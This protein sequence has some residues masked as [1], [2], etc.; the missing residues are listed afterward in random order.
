MA[1]TYTTYLTALATI[2]GIP[3]T[4]EAF[5]AIVPSAIDYAEGRI[6]RELDM[7]AANVR[8]SSGTLTGGDRNFTLPIAVG[9]FQVVDGINVITPAAA[10]SA[11][12]GTRNACAPVS[13][14]VLDM[15]YPSSTGSGVPSMFAYLSQSDVSG[16]KHVLFGPWPDANYRVEVVGK[17][18]PPPLSVSVTTTFLSTYLPDL[19]LAA[20]MVFMTGFMKN[21]G[22]QA[23]DPKMALSW[24]AQYQALK[25]SAGTWEARK[26]FAGASWSPNA[27]EPAAVPQRG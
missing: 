12:A 4:N 14:A 10:A 22:A 19:L 18:Q 6:H 9:R 5:A 24:E 25:E 15:I 26:R 2:T 27:P 21:F 7:L 20:S 11:D 3:T 8:D 23:D 16:Q 1:L 13:R 17:V